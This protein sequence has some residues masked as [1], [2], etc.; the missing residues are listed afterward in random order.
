MVLVEHNPLFFSNAC[1]I[2]CVVISALILLV[3]HRSQWWWWFIRNFKIVFFF[4]VHD[5]V[6]TISFWCGVYRFFVF[7]LNWSDADAHDE[8]QNHKWIMHL[9]IELRRTYL[10]FTHSHIHTYNLLIDQMIEVRFGGVTSFTNSPDSMNPNFK[11]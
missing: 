5:F 11:V 2:P 3:C 8:F 10:K 4:I 7:I 1:W 9:S 6:V